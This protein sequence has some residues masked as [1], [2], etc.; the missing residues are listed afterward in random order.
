MAG[1]G[2][3]TKPEAYWFLARFR[4]KRPGATVI[5]RRR[6][7]GLRRHAHRESRPYLREDGSPDGFE[8]I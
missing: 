5:H 7:G 1:A 4:K 3:L 6:N 2:G 8:W